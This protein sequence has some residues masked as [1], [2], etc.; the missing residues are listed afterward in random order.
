MAPDAVEIN[1]GGRDEWR[2]GWADRHGWGP[3][4]PYQRGRASHASQPFISGRES[5]VV[6]AGKVRSRCADLVAHR[7]GCL[8]RIPD[9]EP[10]HTTRLVPA[11][12]SLAHG[13]WLARAEPETK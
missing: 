12:P 3:G 1:F 4:G 9:R 13:T 2:P 7:K 8:T 5:G 10:G 11:W 6:S